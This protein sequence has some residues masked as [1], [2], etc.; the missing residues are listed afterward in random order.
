AADRIGRLEALLGLPPTESDKKPARSSAERPVRGSNAKR[1]A[2]TGRRRQEKQEPAI[3]LPSS[4]S[5]IKLDLGE[6]DWNFGTLDAGSPDFSVVRGGAPMAYV[7]N[8]TLQDFPL[9]PT[10]PLSYSLIEPGHAFSDGVANMS[11]VPAS[12]GYLP[13]PTLTDFRTLLQSGMRID[14]SA[15]PDILGTPSPPVYT[16]SPLSVEMSIFD[17]LPPLPDAAQRAALINVYFDRFTKSFPFMSRRRFYTTTAHSRN[18]PLVLSMLIV[19]TSFLPLSARGKAEIVMGMYADRL[20]PYLISQKHTLHVVMALFHL[21]ADSLVVGRMSWFHDCA[22][23]CVAG[24]RLAS[25]FENMDANLSTG[26]QNVEVWLAGEETRRTAWFVWWLDRMVGTWQNSS[27][28]IGYE[29]LSMVPLPVH[30]TIWSDDSPSNSSTPMNLL[31][32]LS[33]PES[34]LAAPTVEQFFD[35]ESWPIEA[36]TDVPLGSTA[37]SLALYVHCIQKILDF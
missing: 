31:N 20:L 22:K 6:D 17:G 2:H 34:L 23:C 18:K 12:A 19:A 16:P 21:A 5:N 29:E 9:D 1:P 37:L 33:R 11:T 8:C 30:E 14:L 13:T 15:F 3:E 26:T 28:Q 32:F 24:L 4:T 25:I 35:Y 36:T 10:D 7:N 27:G